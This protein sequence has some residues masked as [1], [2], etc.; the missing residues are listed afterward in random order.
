M[1][2]GCCLDACPQFVKIEIPRKPGESEEHYQTRRSESYDTHF[3]GAHAISQAVLFNSHPIGD[4][5]AGE[6]LDALMAPGGLQVCGNAQN[7]V[8]VC[9]KEI[10]L[11][12]SIAR[13][14]RATTLHTIKL[15]FD[16]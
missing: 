8:A 10:P 5:I 15:I 11:T 6:R 1:S 16:R 12:T 2:C 13:A 3:L 14:G 9:P 4:N 7:C